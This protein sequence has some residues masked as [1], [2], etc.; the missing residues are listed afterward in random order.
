[1][2][3]IKICGITRQEDAAAAV[4]LGVHA[5]GF[6]LWPGS[7]RRVAF[8][9][10][11][12]I[13]SELPPLVTPVG[14]FVDPTASDVRRAVDVGIRVAQ[15]HGAE[16]DWS[17]RPPATILRAV[18][19]ATDWTLTDR[20]IDPLSVTVDPPVPAT[21]AVLLD[22]HDDTFHG[23]TGKT[24]DWERAALVARSRPVLLAGGLT[25]SNVIEA[26]HTVRPYGVDVASGVEERPGVK[27]HLRLRHFVDAVRRADA[28]PA[29]EAMEELQ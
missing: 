8:D 18:R 12:R 11:R 7:P 13:V 22:A 15:I 28:E 24:V 23:G 21:I 14:V 5:L 20:Q 2:T 29:D 25:P 17:G 4:R 19:L 16:P 26:I 6:I 9:E 10:M 27:S 3:A 1:M